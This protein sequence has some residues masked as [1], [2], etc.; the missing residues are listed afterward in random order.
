M[1]S[2]N[3][4]GSLRNIKMIDHNSLLEIKPL[5]HEN[6][7]NETL[8]R[9]GIISRKKKIIYQSCHLMKQYDN[10]YLVHFKQLF[11]LST[12]KDGFAGFGDV[13]DKDI[14]RR[15]RIAY[16]LIKWNMIEVINPADIEPHN[17]YVDTLSYEEAL[18]YEKIRKF[19]LNN[20]VL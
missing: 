20:L 9:M 6:I 5:V 19:N 11:P 4:T 10:Y 12:N 8:S 3:S 17:I 14:Q 7:I 1:S 15:N 2:R 13:T 16:L 18:E